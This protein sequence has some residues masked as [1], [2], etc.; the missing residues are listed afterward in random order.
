[1]GFGI[2]YAL[3]RLGVRAISIYVAVG[4]GIWFAFF[5]S[6]V[7]PTMTGVLLGLLT[8]A[9]EWVGPESL[10]L[11]VADLAARLED[12]GTASPEEYSLIAFAARESISPLER[13]ETGLHPWVGFVIM[14][15]FAL[16]NA[17]VHVEV[18]ELTHSVAL[19]VA[20][21]LLLGKPI[22]IV[23]FSYLA[24]R[25]GV[26]KLPDG[27]NWWVLLG[28]GILAGIGFTMSLFIAGLALGSDEHLLAAGKIGTLTGSVLSALL[29]AA[30]LLVVLR[31]K[32][33][34]KTQND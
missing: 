6:G 9:R 24:I 13:L 2:T 4:I 28:G 11:S 23:L 33:G 3:N 21:G 32:T 29:G 31:G 5:H 10:R 34:P 15:L 14:P 20:L 7:H 27:V 30:V 12:D 16:A 19:A 22:G 17:A 18:D 1:M 25:L 8:P 26:A